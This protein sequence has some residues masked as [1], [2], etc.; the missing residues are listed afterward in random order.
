M[1]DQKKFK[2]HPFWFES[3]K[4]H[5]FLVSFDTFQVKAWQNLNGFFPIQGDKLFPN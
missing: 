1:A 5:Q 3:A 2:F 4:N